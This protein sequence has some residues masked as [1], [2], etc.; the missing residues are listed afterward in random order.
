ME[1][2]IVY[3]GKMEAY[4]TTITFVLR[5]FIYVMSCGADVYFKFT[6]VFNECGTEVN[7]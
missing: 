6:A 7:V 2:H 1:L 4:F 3:S 5:H